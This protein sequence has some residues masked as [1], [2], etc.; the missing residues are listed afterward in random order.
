MENWGGEVSFVY[1]SLWGRTYLS[2]GS[3]DTRVLWV[4]K[5]LKGMG[6]MVETTGHYDEKT[7]RAVR[8]FQREFGLGADG[9]VGPRTAALLYQMSEP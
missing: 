8:K 1:P 7:K 5:V 9:I 4:Q 2:K 3:E 6:Y